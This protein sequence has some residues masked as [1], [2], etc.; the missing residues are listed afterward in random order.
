MKL[1]TARVREALEHADRFY[2][3]YHAAETFGGPS[4]YF[5]RRALKTRQP[6]ASPQHLEYV[7]ATLASWGMHRMGSGGSKMRAFDEFRAS[8]TPLEKKI[9]QG[10]GFSRRLTVQRD[11]RSMFLGLSGRRVRLLVRS[12]S[13]ADARSGRLCECCA[14]F[15]RCQQVRHQCRSLTVPGR[16]WSQS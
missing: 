9:V 4:L 2:A 10:V 3:A 5:H 16:L 13:D 7:Y 6:P 14:A 8:G 11:F 15:V 12:L 1:N